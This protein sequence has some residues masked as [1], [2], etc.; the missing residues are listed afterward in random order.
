MITNTN[1][2]VFKWR[3][4]K[5]EKWVTIS[6]IMFFSQ[7]SYYTPNKNISRKR[8]LFDILLPFHVNCKCNGRKKSQQQNSHKIWQQRVDGGRHG[9]SV[10]DG[11]IREAADGISAAWD[12]DGPGS[13]VLLLLAAKRGFVN[14]SAA[15]N[16]RA[17]VTC[18]SSISALM[19]LLGSLHTALTLKRLVTISPTVGQLVSTFHISCKIG[20]L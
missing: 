12:G 11:L 8:V 4:Q 3:W 5:K 19:S 2:D 13:R 7:G 14:K 1:H 20:A 17:G 16:L 18:N 10:Q 9:C 6:I 15:L